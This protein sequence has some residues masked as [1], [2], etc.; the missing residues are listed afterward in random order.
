MGMS[1]EESKTRSAV[2]MD[3]DR[4]VRLSEKASPRLLLPVKELK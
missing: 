4:V 1:M 3:C 2:F